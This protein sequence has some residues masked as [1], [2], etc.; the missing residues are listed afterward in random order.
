MSCNHDCSHDNSC[1]RLVP[2]FQGLNSEEEKI[3][4]KETNH[5]I[6]RKGDFIFREGDTSETLYI[7][8]KG[9]IKI[10][11]VAEDG[12]EQ[13]VRLLFPGDFFGQTALFQSEIHYANAEAIDDTTICTIHRQDFLK[14]LERNHDMSLR[15]MHALNEIIHQAD[16]WMT[17]L[18]LME[19]EKRLA[20]VLLLFS[21]RANTKDG[22]FKLPI[23]KKALASLIGTTPETIS[24]KLV[25]FVS[26]EIISMSGQRD[27]QIL[28]LEKIKRIA[29]P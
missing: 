26:D 19:V 5:R 23:S 18:S 12:K 10:N 16:E 20:S 6:F 13:I 2:I 27:I 24:R 22:K 3:L 14:T 15:F 1:I 17:L 28:N 9:L 21:D 25:T 4:Q 11:K 7:V 8:N 29:K